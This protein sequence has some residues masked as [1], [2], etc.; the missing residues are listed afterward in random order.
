MIPSSVARRYAR[1]LL[2]LGLDEDRFEKFGDELDLIMQALEDNRT[3]AAFLKNPGFTAVANRS[4]LNVLK[5][6]LK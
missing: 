1:A 2:A 3:A 5:G 6:T 4:Q